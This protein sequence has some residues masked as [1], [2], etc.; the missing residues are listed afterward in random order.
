MPTTLKTIHRKT[1]IVLKRGGRIF[2]SIKGYLLGNKISTYW[3]V[4][5]VNFGDLLTPLI[6]K[7][8]GFSPVWYP[9]QQAQVLSTGSIL[10]RTP[11]D[12]SGHIIGSGLI[13]DTTRCFKKAKIWAV[14]GKLTRERINAPKATALGD[15][16]LLSSKLLQQRQ[17]RHYALGIVPHFVDQEDPRIVL[18]KKRYKKDV[19]VIDVARKPPAVFKDI[20]KCDCIFSSSLH[21]IIVADSFNIPNAWIYLSDK[22]KGKGFK[23]HDYFSSTGITR[24]PLY[25]DGTENLSQMLKNS[26]KPPEVMIEGLKERLDSTFRCFSNFFTSK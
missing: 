8:Y 25:L 3:F 12:Y 2:P 21:G 13:K 20:D 24:N 7:Y 15:P 19:L 5:R 23:F 1:S 11:E 4:K 10:Q 26:H 18:I 22:L 9:M 17:S 6:L 16:G 14:R